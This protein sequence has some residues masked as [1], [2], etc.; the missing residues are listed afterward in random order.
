MASSIA[1]SIRCISIHALCEEGD[2]HL[3]EPMKAIVKFLSTPSA[4]RATKLAGGIEHQRLI[5][6]HALCEEGDLPASR[7]SRAGRISI[8][9]LCEEGDRRSGQGVPQAAAIS[10]HALCEEGD[11]VVPG[12]H[13]LYDYF[14]PRPLR[15]G[16]RYRQDGKSEASRFLSTPSARRATRKLLQTSSVLHYFYPRPLRGGRRQQ[17]QRR[18][19]RQK[20][21]STPSARRATSK[22]AKNMK[23]A[24]FLSTPSARRATCICRYFVFL[25]PFLSTPSARRAT[26]TTGCACRSKQIS[27]HALCEEGDRTCRWCG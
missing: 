14:Y 19:D 25:F 7:G 2:T 26:Q 3:L 1:P 6:I 27:I 18:E 11:P 4:R 21:L 10:I 13:Q 9:A 5:S 24:K 23:L 8:H 22:G 16:R 12:V 17:G 20:F 15:G